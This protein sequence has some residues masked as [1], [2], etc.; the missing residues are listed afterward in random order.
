MAG[1]PPPFFR[2]GTLNLSGPARTFSLLVLR[3]A[4]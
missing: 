4:I 3:K 1:R 2:A